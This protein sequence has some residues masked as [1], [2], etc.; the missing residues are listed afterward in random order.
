MMLDTNVLVS[1]FSKEDRYHE[2]ARRFIDESKRQLII[3]V[4]VLIETWGMLVGSR[5]KDRRAGDSVVGWVNTPGK[6][7]LLPQSVDRAV[8]VQSLIGTARVDCVDAMVFQLA[9]QISRQMPGGDSIYVATYDT[10]D[11][12]KCMQAHGV[13]IKIFDM[14]ELP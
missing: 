12:Y 9:T 14:R 7:I 8:D 4:A 1:A 3:P 10:S 13:R 5:I 11:F 2:P 6:A